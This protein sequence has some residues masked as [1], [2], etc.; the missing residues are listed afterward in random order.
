MRGRIAAVKR[1]CYI[2]REAPYGYNKVVIG[3]DHTLEPSEDADIVR[4]VFDMYVNQGKTYYQIACH[5]NDLKIQSPRGGIWC[6]DTIRKMLMND[7][8]IGKVSFNKIKNTTMVENGVRIT[9]KLSQPQEEVIIAEG[10]HPAIIDKD[11]FQKAQE[12]LRKNP[13]TKKDFALQNPFA[14]IMYCA[15][16]GKAITRHPYKLAG[17][18][19]ECRSRPKCY[20]SA[21]YDD[22][23]HAVITALEQSELPALQ[24]KMRNGEGNSIAIQKKLLERLEKQM[25]DFRKQEEKQYDLLE[26]GVYTQDRF[27]QRN[28]AL[29]QKIEECQEKIYETKATMPKQVDYAE[30]V[31]SLEKAIAALKNPEVSAEVK[32][33]LLKTIIK[34]IE[35]S[36]GET[37]HNY[38]EIKLKFIMRL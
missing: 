5:L 4:L 1:G 33:R 21:K 29:R 34:R 10:K 23:E 16:C 17:L 20:K 38:T 31:V 35:F 2:G 7:H 19:L 15:G 24:T 9:K 3:K 36:T 30:R 28:A 18:R 37:G 32:N 25:E 6:R 22:V 12:R 14:G 27:E 13:S 8:Y 26:T 11:I